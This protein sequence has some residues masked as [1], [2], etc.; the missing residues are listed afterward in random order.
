MRPVSCSFHAGLGYSLVASSFSTISFFSAWFGNVRFHV[1]D[2]GG[3]TRVQIRVTR[4]FGLFQSTAEVI[5]P[6]GSKH[7]L[8]NGSTLRIGKQ[9]PGTSNDVRVTLLEFERAPAMWRK[10]V[11]V[12]AA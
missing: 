1:A 7:R 10:T 8:P 5:G 11:P 6:V 9:T 2:M 4:L 12:P 3:S